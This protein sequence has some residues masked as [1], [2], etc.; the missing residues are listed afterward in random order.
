MSL[1]PSTAPTATGWSDSCRAG[2]APAEEWRLC[3]AHCNNRVHL[4]REGSSL[5]ATQSRKGAPTCSCNAD[6]P[7]R[8]DPALADP[9][10][11][12]GES[13]RPVLHRL[14]RR[15][16]QRPVS[17]KPAVSHVRHH[18]LFRMGL[19]SA[20]HITS[21][22]PQFRQIPPDILGDLLDFLRHPGRKPKLPFQRRREG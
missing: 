16:K 12:R 3:T 5:V 4:P 19:S 17:S 11:V 21:C 1:P 6:P 20:S 18:S 14:N 7:P 13:G 10:R 15:D 8:R 9:P 22:I 2:F